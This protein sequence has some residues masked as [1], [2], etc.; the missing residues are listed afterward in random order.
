[1][2]PVAVHCCCLL[3]L[4]AS[5]L[6]QFIIHARFGLIRGPKFSRAPGSGKAGEGGSKEAHA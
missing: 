4:A 5:S 2:S 3:L 6:I 1:M